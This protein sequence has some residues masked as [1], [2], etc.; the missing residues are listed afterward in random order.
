MHL[1]VSYSSLEVKL[2]AFE[3]EYSLC[4]EVFPEYA[5]S[6]YNQ[7]VEIS[8]L[9]HEIEQFRLRAL[10]VTSAL[11]NSTSKVISHIV[12]HD[13]LCDGIFLYAVIDHKR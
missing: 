4:R 8:R 1:L 3:D 12:Q 2:L 6:D 5:W 9:L 7:G 13:W 10:F 11:C